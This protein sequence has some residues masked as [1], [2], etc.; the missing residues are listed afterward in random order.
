[1]ADTQE[2]VKTLQKKGLKVEFRPGP[3]GDRWHIQG[4]SGTHIVSTGQ[5]QELYAAKKLN[6]AG[7]KE[8]D[9]KLKN[10]S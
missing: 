5:L 1:M 7:I 6:M 4:H 2:L 9:E 10:Q 8:L 3:L